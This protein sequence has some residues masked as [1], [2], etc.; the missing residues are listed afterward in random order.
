MSDPRSPSAWSARWPAFA[1]LA[2]V[3]LA[4]VYA[5]A[6][7]A[8]GPGARPQV[9]L[10]FGALFWTCAL[11]GVLMLAM[12]TR[13]FDAGWAPVLRRSWEF[14][15]PAL[16]LVILLGIAP[17]AVLPELRHAVWEWTKAD[18]H[19][20][21]AKSW[22]LNE[23]F[24]LG[25]IAFYV[26]FFAVLAW[27]L[28]RWSFA[29]DRDRTA[30]HTHVLHG[31]SAVGIP[32]AAL[33][34]TLLA[35]DC[36]MALSYHWFSTMYGVW[37]FSLSIRLALALTVIVAHLLATRGWLAGILN[38]AHRHVLGCLMLAFTVFWAYISFSQYFIIYSAN[39][40]EETFWYNL[41]EIDP[42]TGLKNQWWWVSMWLVF[43]FFLLPFLLLLFYRTKIVAS[44]LVAVAWLIL[45]GCLADLQFNAVPRKDYS[46]ATVEPFLSPYLALDLLSV[47]GFGALV[48]AVFLRSAG[49][50]ECIPVHDPRIQESLDYHE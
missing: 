18:D 19:A 49:R 22:F 13:I 48:A 11:V 38:Q 40:P 25:R 17:L 9:S 41:R 37:F 43:G 24:F 23:P 16:P 50:A 34:L 35:F 15:L 42:S 5:L 7:G 29:Q 32:L 1:G 36:L 26:A 3:A 44:R 46:T 33:V 6:L 45:L 14:A 12:I 27:A 31:I 28:R 21:H 4:G 8:P 39:I 2:V 20:I 47:L 10:L 30:S